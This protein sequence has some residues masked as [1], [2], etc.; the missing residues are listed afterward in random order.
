MILKIFVNK[1]AVKQLL[2]YWG[3]K[4]IEKNRWTW[5]LDSQTYEL[6]VFAG[7]LNSLVLVEVEFSSIEQANNFQPADW[8]GRE[9]TTEKCYKNKALAMNPNAIELG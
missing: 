4:Q 2:L 3:G 1:S 6:D 5:Q 9:V 7:A 8:F